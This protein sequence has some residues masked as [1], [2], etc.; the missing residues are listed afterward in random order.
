[1]L[2]LVLF[3]ANAICQNNIAALIDSAENLQESNPLK[4]LEYAEL[5]EKKS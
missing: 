5:A 4:A 1:M 3:T 2:V